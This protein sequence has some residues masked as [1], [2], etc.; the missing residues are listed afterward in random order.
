[1]EDKCP[2]CLGRRV[3]LE[4]NVLEV[5]IERGMKDGQRIVC[6]GQADDYVSTYKKAN[7]KPI[8]L[9]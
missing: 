6:P 8:I 2:Q 1:M 5:V 9:N 7:V 4:K 3:T